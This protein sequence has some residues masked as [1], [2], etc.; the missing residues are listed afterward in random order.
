MS[1]VDFTEKKKNAL[2]DGA[3]PSGG[4]VRELLAQLHVVALHSVVAVEEREFPEADERVEAAKE[5]E[6]EMQQAELAV[7]CIVHGA[8]EQGRHDYD[9]PNQLATTHKQCGVRLCFCVTKP[10]P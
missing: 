8:G 3:E 1:G 7:T 4:G 5:V 2:L 6:K 9:E 10:K